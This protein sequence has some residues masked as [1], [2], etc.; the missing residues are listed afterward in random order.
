MR[1]LYHLYS[2]YY[3]IPVDNSKV[4]LIVISL[5]AILIIFG[6]SD[7]ELDIILNFRLP[8]IILGIIIGAGLASSGCSLQ[9]LFKNSL[10][11]PY[12]LGVSSGAA[13]G[14]VLATLIGFSTPI[15]AFLLGLISVFLIYMLARR[16]GGLS[17]EKIILSGIALNSLFSAMTLLLIYL[18]FPNR[19]SLFLFWFLGTLSNAS[20][21]DVLI[22][23]PFFLIS[24]LIMLLFARDLDLMAIDE[25]GARTLGVRVELVKPAILFSCALCTSIAVSTVG[26]IGFV[27]LIIPH[28][29]RTL[30]G[31]NNRMI[32]PASALFG[33]LLLCTCDTIARIFMLPV[34]I[35]TSLIGAPF[36]LYLLSKKS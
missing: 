21:A 17:T 26:I 34:G 7:A 14:A 10:A 18:G 19:G 32:I 29:M 9:S 35:L 22:N 23:L 16:K 28:I 3:I 25:K 15:S 30:L 8:R 4:I 27:G 36:F 11:E 12:I 31:L 6:I 5:L 20:W 1:R 13:L 2:I 33:G 24:I